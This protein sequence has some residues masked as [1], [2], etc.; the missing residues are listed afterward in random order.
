MP[1]IAL[2]LNTAAGRA[3]VKA[4]WRA[5][6]GLVPGEPN[7]GLTA[8]LLKTPARDRD[9]DDSGWEVCENVRAS[10]SVG[11][12]FAW[13]RLA[14]EVPA[15]IEGQSTAGARIL[16][17]TNVDN[18][19]EVWVNGAINRATG[20]VLGLDAQHRVEVSPEAKA[21]DR[22]VIAVLAVN[23][24]LAEPRGGVFLRYATLAFETRG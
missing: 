5:A 15:Q 18:Y 16:F 8:E 13:Y 17:E 12:C 21:G 7:Q 10:R 24:P 2:D 4:Q 6:D 11:F 22:H 1:R 23:G 20:A 3:A 9:Y 14:I 19:A